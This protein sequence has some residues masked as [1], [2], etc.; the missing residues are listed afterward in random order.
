M[1]LAAFATGCASPRPPKP[2]SLNLPQP[3]KD[4][5]AERIGNQVL[6]HWTTPEKTTD[7]FE[8]KG[9]V[10]AEVCRIVYP[11]GHAASDCVPITRLPVRSGPTQC[12]ETLPQPLTNDP[13]TLLGYRV[14]LLNAHGRSSGFSQQ[15]F[16]AAGAAPPAVDQLRAAAS[17]SGILLQWRV[18]N[19]QAIV[20]LDRLPAGA[21]SV[22]SSSANP[23]AR[24]ASP[25]LSQKQ[26][27]D[28]RKDKSKTSR[29]SAHPQPPLP[30]EIRLRTPERS[31]D[32]G[33]TSDQTAAK[34]ETY[35]YTAQR[36][37]PVSLEGHALALRSLPSP[38]VTVT[39]R[40]IFPPAIPTG[41]EAVPGGVALSDRSIDLSWT[42]DDDSDIAGYF[43]YRQPVSSAGILTG[44]TILLTHTP[45]AEPAFRD[46]TVV[47]GQ[48]YAYRVTAVDAR[49]NQSAPSADAQETLLEP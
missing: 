45:I 5:T 15:A 31:T 1:L 34:G 2:P 10:T 9:P 32:P 28:Q 7:G 22:S 12:S 8:I 25:D 36:V 27:K 20:E 38:P 47:I 48:R 3:V 16:A 13:V 17:P 11:A 26:A 23:P 44:S 29:T 37:L 41:L 30:S 40:D 24:S 33:G 43:V 14:Q 21:A 18:E 35:R 42:P 49:G 6:L 4:L 39:F 46:H 19:T